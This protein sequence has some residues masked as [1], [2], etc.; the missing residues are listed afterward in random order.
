MGINQFS[1]NDIMNSEKESMASAN[2]DYLVEGT[3]ECL[4]LVELKTTNSSYNEIQFERYLS[5][6]TDENG[7]NKMWD[8]YCKLIDEKIFPTYITPNNNPRRNNDKYLTHIKYL[9]QVS[10]IINNNLKD[11]NDSYR[12][13]SSFDRDSS[14]QKHMNQE[15]NDPVANFKELNPKKMENAEQYNLNFS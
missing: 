5:Y 13:M 10:G 2:A 8:F 1:I 12:K 14:Y 11:M 15:M 3:D 6:V 7:A 4:Y 9:H